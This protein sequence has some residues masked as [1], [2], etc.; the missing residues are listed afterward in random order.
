MQV[1]KA[2]MV[3]NRSRI[4][5]RQ[6]LGKKSLKFNKTKCNIKKNSGR[7]LEF[8]Q[9]HQMKWKSSFNQPARTTPSHQCHR[10]G[11]DVNVRGS[12][13]VSARYWISEHR[14][15]PGVQALS[16]LVIIKLRRIYNTDLAYS[17][18]IKPERKKILFK[19]WCQIEKE[20]FQANLKFKWK[21]RRRSIQ[22]TRNL[23]FK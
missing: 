12:L 9:K 22:L 11:K 17:K 3:W 5:Y 2:L 8:H 18:E 19:N 23:S 16:S 7:N 13:W 15:A 4:L 20:Q 14:Y 10:S 6:N 1:W 21:I